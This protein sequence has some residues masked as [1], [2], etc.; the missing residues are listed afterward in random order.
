MESHGAEPKDERGLVELQHLASDADRTEQ[1]GDSA[2]QYRDCEDDDEGAQEPEQ[3][4]RRTLAA[5]YDRREADVQRTLDLWQG[6]HD[7][8]GVD[9]SDQDT[10]HHDQ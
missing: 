10:G 6:Q 7:D 8:G 4:R 2:A 5:V 9:R 3:C 1:E